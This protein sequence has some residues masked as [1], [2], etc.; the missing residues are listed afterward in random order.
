MDEQALLQALRNT[1]TRHRAFTQIVNQYSEKVY[2]VVRHI[3]GTHEDADDVVQN[4]FIKL[5]NKID[6]FRGDSKLST[7]MHRV[8]VNEALDF[9]RREKKHKDNLTDDS[10]ITDHTSGDVSLAG[11]SDIYFDGDELDKVLR[12]IID[13]LPEAQRTVFCMKYFDDMSYKEI[14]EIL[15]TS[16]GGLK[17]NYHHAVEKIKL[18]LSRRMTSI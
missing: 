8:A 15:G 17:A 18:N 1:E 7:W 6:D 9:L 5:W 3:V 4:T 12:D 10:V 11:F 14:S 2:W 13:T 16:E